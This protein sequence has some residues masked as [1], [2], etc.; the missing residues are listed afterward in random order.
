MLKITG[1]CYLSSLLFYG[2]G[3]SKVLVLNK[4]QVNTQD[5]TAYVSLATVS[6]V[7]TIFLIVVGSLFYY[8]K[9]IKDQGI[10]KT[11]DLQSKVNKRRRRAEIRRRA[12]KLGV[13]TQLTQ[14]EYEVNLD[15][16]MSS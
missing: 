1:A 13:K 15:S 9:N 5:F 14:I 4:G 2:I 7:L 11:D 3:Y 16:R 10:I 6:F 8:V 12:N